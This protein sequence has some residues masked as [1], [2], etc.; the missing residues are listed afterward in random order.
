MLSEEE[1]G[2]AARASERLVANKRDCEQL[3]AQSLLRWKEI[4][5]VI[6]RIGRLG[7]E[8]MSN[9]PATDWASGRRFGSWEN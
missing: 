1:V 4:A 2:L 3:L 7:G 8:T 6:T 9:P 5:L